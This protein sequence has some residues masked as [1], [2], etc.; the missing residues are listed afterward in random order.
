MT[1]K[2]SLTKRFKELPAPLQIYVFLVA[3]QIFMYLFESLGQLASR[4]THDTAAS[5]LVLCVLMGLITLGIVFK[6][7]ISRTLAL[8]GAW[9]MIV[10]GG[11]MNVSVLLLSFDKTLPA[12]AWVNF[13]EMTGGI[14]L[15]VLSLYL[16]LNRK[17]RAFFRNGE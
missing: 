14:I 3:A 1:T 11:V 13:W 4:E 12:Y 5:V 7:S 8:V 10:F 17:T 15:A 6:S 9:A 2:L 16:L